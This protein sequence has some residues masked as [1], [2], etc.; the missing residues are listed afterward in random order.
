[1][2]NGVDRFFTGVVED[3][4]DPFMLGRVRVRVHGIH[5]EQKVKAENYG[6]ATD[7]LLW[8]TIGTST[9]SASIS[10]VGQSPTGIV[11]GTHVYGFY[12][13]D[14]YQSGLIMGTYPGIYPEMPNFNK[15]FTDPNRQFPRYV[16]SDVNILARGGKEIKIAPGQ[17]AQTEEIVPA[18]VEDQDL[19]R[20]WAAEPNRTPNDEIKPNPNPDVTIEDMLRYDEGIRVVVYWDSEGYPTVGIGHL[21][22][23]EKTKNMSRINSLL[24]QQVGRQVQGRIT[25]EDCST[26]FARDLNGVY[27]DISRS[28]TVGPVYSMLDD[29]RKMAIINMTF[30]MGIGGVANFQKMLAYL[31]LGQYDKA[32]DE[33]LDSLWA[34]Q[35]PNRARRV[36]DV[37]RNG[38]LVAYGGSQGSVVRSITRAVAMPL[39]ATR[40][41]TR[42]AK[43]ATAQTVSFKEP[44]SAYSAVYPY[45]KVFES[46]SGHIQEFD[47]TPGHERIHTRHK[48]GTFEE[49]H[50]DG[51]KVQKIIGDD[52]YIVKNNRNVHV[53]GNLKFIVDG[54]AVVFVQGDAETTISGNANQFI[55]GDSI[56]RVEGNVN[57][58]VTGS[59]N[60]YVKGNVDSQIDGN[61]A[62]TVNQN[63]NIKVVGDCFNTI[64]GNY[65]LK[66]GGNFSTEVGGTR[67][68]QVGGNWDRSASTVNDIAQGTF[69]INGSRINLG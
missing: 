59:V 6:M 10:G 2:L 33:A 45:N 26:L 44:A 29:T 60:Q 39:I 64:D 68:D 48:A 37:I 47:D 49:I 28:A 23:H 1:M 62:A 42:K 7:D 24:S 19:N 57:Q 53:G 66:V 12:L 34:R 35:T 41:I 31:A 22:I 9:T 58:H 16:G 5:P 54:N 17:I 67:N 18:T 27:S 13:D 8:M 3:R 43:T 40:S 25:E 50:P 32:A 52:F 15:G 65:V 61:M 30:Q 20:D 36:T 38:N 63:A 11:E 21:I 51:T 69:S 14:F 4:F 55:R 46:E 56:E